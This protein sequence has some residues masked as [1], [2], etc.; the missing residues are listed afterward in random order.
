M[1]DGEARA[2][3]SAGG[4]LQ[5]RGPEQCL[6]LVL[7]LRTV[8]FTLHREAVSFN[9]HTSPTILAHLPSPARGRVPAHAHPSLALPRPDGICSGARSPPSCLRCEAAPALIRP[10]RR[11]IR[12]PI[13]AAGVSGLACRSPGLARSNREE[14]AHVRC[15]FGSWGDRCRSLT[16]YVFVTEPTDGATA[17]GGC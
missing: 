10:I 4:L 1:A 5:L 12:R 3:T 14:G 16:P 9:P 8:C 2:T 17:A 13:D 11:S 15:G 6:S 7:H